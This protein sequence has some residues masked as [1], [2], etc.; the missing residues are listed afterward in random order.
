MTKRN[1]NDEWYTP[2]TIVEKAKLVLGTIDVDPASNEI[3][4]QY[5][6]AKT[7]YTKEINGLDKPWNGTVWCNPP[8]SASLLKKFTAKFLGEYELGNMKEGIMLTNSG[9]DT[10]WNI[11]LQ[12]GVQLYTNGRIS[13]MLPDGT[14]KDKGSRGQ[15]FTYLGPNPL[16]F[17]KVFTEDNFCWCPN[18]SLLEK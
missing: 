17:I 7:F 10:K 3:T 5:I 15:C 4:Q 11:P 14:Y 1:S 8:Y 16:K 9:T 18:L 6:K 13:F 2:L 12:K